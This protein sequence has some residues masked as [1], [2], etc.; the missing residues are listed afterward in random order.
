LVKKSSKVGKVPNLEFAEMIDFSSKMYADVIEALI[1]AVFLD[2]L[3]ID[4][5][6]KWWTNF[7]M[8]YIKVY[9]NKLHPIEKYYSLFVNEP[10]LMCM[11]KKKFTIMN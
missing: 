4:E 7:M 5:T 8:D 1:G 6:E 10:E 2:T 9:K 3:S 11:E